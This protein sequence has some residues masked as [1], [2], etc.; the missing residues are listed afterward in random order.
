MGSLAATSSYKSCILL[1]VTQESV[2]VL[3]VTCTSEHKHYHP[4]IKLY[5][6]KYHSF[7][8]VGIVTHTAYSSN[9]DGNKLMIFSGL[10][11][12]DTYIVIAATV[13]AD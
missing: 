9:T 2:S 11:Y 3:Q 12:G 8:A 4:S 1:Q 7:F 5:R 13:V 10:Y 6:N